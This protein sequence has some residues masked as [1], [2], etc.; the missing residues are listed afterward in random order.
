MAPTTVEEIRCPE[1]GETTRLRFREWD[2]SQWQTAVLART[3]PSQWNMQMIPKGERGT[4]TVSSQYGEIYD[5]AG[6]TPF[7][8]DLVCPEGHTVLKL[9]PWE[10][11]ELSKRLAERVDSQAKKA[12]R[13]TSTIFLAVM[14]LFFLLLVPPTF[15]LPVESTITFPALVLT[16]LAVYLV[17]WYALQKRDRRHLEAQRQSV[18]NEEFTSIHEIR[19][20]R[21]RD[22][23]ER[24]ARREHLESL[25]PRE[26]EFA[27]AEILELGGYGTAELGPGVADFGADIL[28]RKDNNLFIAQVKQWANPVQRQEIQ[29]LQ[30]AM[31]HF[32][33]KG[34]IF[35]TLGRFSEKAVLYAG[36][37]EIVAV[38]GETLVQM[39]RRGTT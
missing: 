27:V 1:C 13:R 36:Q 8:A 6:S 24:I 38:D 33:A 28:L 30:G 19:M 22:S 34:G 26:F 23:Q 5:L 3:G 2:A 10:S 12:S 11:I 39:A 4:I 21:E 14:L 29:K 31:G 25:S 15:A 16:W 37:H 35:V 18:A 32:G 17:A 7:F 20:A 9:H